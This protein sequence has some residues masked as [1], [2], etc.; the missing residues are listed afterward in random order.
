MPTTDMPYYTCSVCYAYY[1]I[2]CYTMLTIPY[3]VILCLLFHTMPTIPYYAAT[4][5]Y[6]AYYFILCLLFHTMP[7]HSIYIIQ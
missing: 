5:P 6:Y 1:S 3:Y 2:L 4:I 7:Y